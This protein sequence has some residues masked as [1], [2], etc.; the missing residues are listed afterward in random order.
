MEPGRAPRTGAGLFRRGVLKEVACN[1]REGGAPRT[2]RWVLPPE[3]LLLIGLDLLTCG[4]LFDGVGA[5]GLAFAA[6]PEGAAAWGGGLLTE[7]L[8]D[9]AALGVVVRVDSFL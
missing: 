8:L 9:G 2:E 1:G 4:L 6:R 7:L 5:C 3:Y